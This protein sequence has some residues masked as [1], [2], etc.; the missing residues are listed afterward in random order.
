MN[1][2]ERHESSKLPGL[3]VIDGPIDGGE[4]VRMSAVIVQVSGSNVEVV[5]QGWPVPSP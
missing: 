5:G 2:L 3:M 1:S 4:Y